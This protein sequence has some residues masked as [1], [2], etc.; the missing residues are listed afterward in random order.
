MTTSRTYLDWNATAALRV[1]AR[2]AMIAAMSS[3]GNP[4]SVH[5]EGRGARETVERARED[6]ARLVNAQPSEVVFTSGATEANNWVMAAGWDVILRAPTEH[7]S[8]LA[9]AAASDAACIAL[10]VDRNGEVDFR[11]IG[12]VPAGRVL[13]VLQLANNE[14]GVVQPV[15]DACRVARERGWSVHCDAVQAPGRIDVDFAQLGVDTLCLSS[16]KIGGPMG[17][18]ALVIGRGA[19]I[20]PFITGGGQERRRRAGTENV[21][22]IAGFA[23]AAAACGRDVSAPQRVKALRDRLE[24]EALAIAPDAVV[25]GAGA[26]ERL[27]NTTSL[28]LPG[29][30]AET[31]VIRLD[32]A[33]I[34]VSAGAACSSG[35]VGASRVLA[36]MG[37][38]RS[39]SEGAIRISLGWSTTDADVDAFL[40]EWRKIAAGQRAPRMVA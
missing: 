33:G 40:A 36:A 10:D 38:P 21:A 35:K 4:S 30:A 25:I 9:P 14:T 2:A 13:L 24:Q 39:V 22:A 15:A 34:A 26:R 32:L 31:L 16:H 7:E 11:G 1:E 12:Q 20:E 19:E 18:G 5:A 8:V 3:Y 27:P 17:V 23:A 6:V 37:L 29:S 28:A